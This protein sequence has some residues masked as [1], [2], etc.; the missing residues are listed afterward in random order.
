MPTLL[1]LK[2]KHVRYNWTRAA[3]DAVENIQQT[4]TIDI[5]NIGNDVSF[6][7]ADVRSKRSK[8]GFL[9]RAEFNQLIDWAANLTCP[10]VLAMPQPMIVEPNPVERNLLSFDDRF[11]ELVKAMESSG[12]DIVLLSGDVHYGRVAT[13]N[14]GNSG[15]RL[16]EIIASPLSNLTGLNGI[17]TSTAKAKPARFPHS[18][19]TVPGVPAQDVNYDKNHFVSH[20][21]GRLLSAYPRDRTREHFMTISLSKTSDGKVQLVADA[22]RVRERAGAK[23][24]PIR[25][26]K[27]PFRTKLK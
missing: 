14:F 23:N 4:N 26:F 16:I 12:H 19:L 5:F 15:G 21:K 7:L 17:A 24:L 11:S 27:N 2:L 25:D 1:S 13:V 9:P 8:N 3:K 10:G 20:K 18:S 6:C 22:W